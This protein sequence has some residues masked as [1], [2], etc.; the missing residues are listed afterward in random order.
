MNEL[1]K[2]TSE[3]VARERIDAALHD[4]TYCTQCGRP[5]LVAVRGA[6]MWVECETLGSKSG[7]RLGIAAGFHDRRQIAL[8]E[9]ILAAA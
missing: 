3:D 7:L 8:P 6:E 5:M 1:T 9:G 4:L 2:T